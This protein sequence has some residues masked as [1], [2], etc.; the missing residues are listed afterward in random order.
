MIKLLYFLSIFFSHEF[1]VSV[2]YM[3]YDDKRRA[4][5]IQKKIFFDDLE[6]AIKKTSGLS[7]FDILNSN[8]DLI[9]KE[10]ENYLKANIQFTIN[11][12]K[13]SNL[14]WGGTFKK[15]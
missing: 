14:Y 12:K 6:F 15:I 9:N 10:I 2:S 1:Y 13:L 11:N 7:D 5:Q 4:I 8:Q 3:E